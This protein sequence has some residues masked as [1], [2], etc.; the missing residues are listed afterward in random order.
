[1]DIVLFSDLHDNNLNHLLGETIGMAILDSGCTRTVCGNQWLDTYLDTL[2]T[3][4]RKSV[5]SKPSV[6]SFRFG[7]GQVYDS[8]RSVVIPIHFGS[9]KA[10]LEVNIVSC[11]VP[12]LL[13]RLSLKRANSK[14][15]FSNDKINILGEQVPIHISNSGHYCISLSRTTNCTT[16]DTEK[17]FFTS[18]VVT[19]DT[20]GNKTK[21]LK[22]HKQFAHPAPE[23]LK[24]LIRNSGSDDPDVYRLVDE[25]SKN[26]DVC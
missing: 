15:D 16:R 11:N 6:C 5:F 18:P 22:L 20:T 1:M 12:L 10:Q 4:E 7:D 8:N 2:S 9:Q 13:S 24:K 26:C 14:L 25:I 19:G 21:V 23:K 3:I 17:I